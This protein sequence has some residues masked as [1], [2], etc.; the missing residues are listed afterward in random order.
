MTAPCQCD[1]DCETIGGCFAVTAPQISLADLRYRN[2]LAPDAQASAR[3][4][5]VLALVAA[6]E[7][8]Q[9]FVEEY[10]RGYGGD[11]FQAFHAALAPLVAEGTE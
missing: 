6:V 4:S 1:G 2:L 8:A 3:S 5:D 10:D 11:E 7:A 9:A